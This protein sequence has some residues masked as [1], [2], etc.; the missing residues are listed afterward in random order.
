VQG[1][2]GRVDCESSKGILVGKYY[3][4]MQPVWAGYLD[5]IKGPGRAIMTV[6]LR[7]LVER[8]KQ[9]RSD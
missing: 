5:L 2:G 3:C 4:E 8:L 6:D 7:P 1:F 9:P